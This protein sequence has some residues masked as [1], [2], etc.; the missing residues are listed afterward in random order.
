M[1]EPGSTE[2]VAT[3]SKL[4]QAIKFNLIFN[5]SIVYF[6]EFQTESNRNV[7]LI[8]LIF[9]QTFL[10]ANCISFFIGFAIYYSSIVFW[11]Q[12]PYAVEW[13]YT[14]EVLVIFSFVTFK[15]FRNPDR[16]SEALRA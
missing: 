12:I 14:K 3:S 11:L 6:R 4:L 13:S 1:F 15:S 2:I 5:F 16:Y 8:F 7:T 10:I 9:S